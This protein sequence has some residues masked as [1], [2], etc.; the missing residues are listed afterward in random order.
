MEFKTKFNP[1]YCCL[2]VFTSS[3]I[4]VRRL[5]QHQPP[6][7][8]S[9]V[10][11]A[12]PVQ[13]VPPAQTAGLTE[14]QVE[15]I[16]RRVMAA[17]IAAMVEAEVRQAMAANI[18]ALFKVEVRRVLESIRIT[19]LWTAHLCLLLSSY[20]FTHSYPCSPHVCSCFPR[21]CAVCDC[22][23]YVFCALVFLHPSPPCICFSILL[24]C[25]HLCLVPSLSISP[26]PVPLCVILLFLP[27]L[28]ILP[29]C[30]HHLLGPGIG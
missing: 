25:V 14:A 8:A 20:T 29:L 15:A 2:F 7:P 6:P 4:D 9:P 24:P 18:A 23:Q 13:P 11:P 3:C 1:I 5:N 28:C 30:L 19:C 26:P 17:D 10:Q 21:V 22:P 16:V 27:L 12:P